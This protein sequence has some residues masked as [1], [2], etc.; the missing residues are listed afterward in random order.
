MKKH[1][2]LLMALMLTGLGYSQV[3]ITELA[4]PDGNANARFIELYNAGSTAVDFTESNGWQ[5]D[6]YTNA[7]A[8]VTYTLDLTGT[9][10]PGGFYII[11]YDYSP[12]TFQ[13]V[14]GFAPDQLDAVQNGV[15]GSN[16][17]DDLFLIDGNDNVVD[18]YGV[19]GE[20]NTGYCSEY[21]D[22]RAERIASV[23]SGNPVWDE[24][25]WNVWA[26]SDAVNATSCTNH[27]VDPQVAPD[28]FDPG[29]WIGAPVTTTVVSFVSSS[30]D[31]NEDI[32]TV[33]VCL[34]IVNP[35]PANDTVVELNLN[36]DSTATNGVDYVNMNFP[37]TLT[38]PAGS[39]DDQ[40]ITID[41]IN[42]NEVEINETIVLFIENV[43][44]GNAAAPVSPLIHTL[45]IDHN[46]VLPPNPG[47]I[48]ITE[49]MQNPDAVPDADGEYFEVYNTTNDP[50]NMFAWELTDTNSTAV[51][52]NKVMGN[53]TN[54][55]IVPPHGYLVFVTN[56]DPVQNG[57][58]TADYDFDG[59]G[60]GLVNGAGSLT[61]SAAGVVID[62]V[63]W[64]DGVT[65][66]DPTGA[67]ME[68][69]LSHYNAVDNDDGANWCE[70]VS[71]YGAGDKGTPGADNDCN[72]VRVI[73]NEIEG[74]AV[75]PN[76]VDK[77][78]INLSTRS[79]S[80]KKVEIY[81]IAGKLIWTK[82]ISGEQV[83]LNI[84]TIK[85][86]LYMLKVKEN[87]KISI[88]KLLIK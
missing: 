73:E 14:Y 88:V 22:G 63:A 58:I 17:D 2:L 9:I 60:T 64:D 21:E 82:E 32:G 15:A 5:I 1:Y 51:L 74:F 45:T 27:V 69:S 19:P 18:A 6:K 67:S 52:N 48:I 76:P 87:N 33:D 56:G 77:G 80:L 3:F 36:P 10:Q 4:D 44:G 23:T 35:D 28:D 68:L 47:D 8:T 65:F 85:A 41:I 16:G 40:C 12:G 54:N 83:S 24:S 39:T 70:A 61:L 57:G 75:F 20:D 46:D 26:D 66:P 13:S 29:A 7:S 81:D 37:Y 72:I 53:I 38:F 42:D 62:E 59:S 43:S 55:T 49:I 78:V 30:T 79:N 11:A 25:E 84:Q 86:G 71:P 31:V 34:S 50:I